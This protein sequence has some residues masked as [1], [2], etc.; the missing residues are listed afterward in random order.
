MCCSS[1]EKAGLYECPLETYQRLAVL[2]PFGELF[3]QSSAQGK[4]VHKKTRAIPDNG[5]PVIRIWQQ[6][7]KEEK[8]PRCVYWSYDMHTFKSET[9]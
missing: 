5:K 4:I 7:K 8:Q 1:I 9:K 3:W 2:L 6:N